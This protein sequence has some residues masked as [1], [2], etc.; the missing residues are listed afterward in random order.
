MVTSAVN[1]AEKFAE[2]QQLNMK[3]VTAFLRQDVNLDLFELCVK[4]MINGIQRKS[5]TSA[6]G[7]IPL[8][9]GRVLPLSS[10]HWSIEKAIMYWLN[11]ARGKN[12]KLEDTHQLLLL[13]VLGNLPEYRDVANGL[14]L[15]MISADR[16]GSEVLASRISERLRATGKQFD[17]GSTTLDTLSQDFKKAQALQ[18]SKQILIQAEQDQINQTLVGF[19]LKDADKLPN[20]QEE[21]I[22]AFYAL[23][24]RCV[25]KTHKTSMDG[26]QKLLVL[27]GGGNKQLIDPLKNKTIELYPNNIETIIGFFD[28]ATTLA[29]VDNFK[30]IANE[31]YNS[32]SIKGANTL[33]PIMKMFG[34]NRLASKLKTSLGVLAL[35]E[36]KTAEPSFAN[37]ILQ[38]W[39]A[40][41]PQGVQ[42]TP[43]VAADWFNAHSVATKTAFIKEFGIGDG[44]KPLDNQLRMI[45]EQNMPH[46]ASSLPSNE[47]SLDKRLDQQSNSIKV[48]Q[49]TTQLLLAAKAFAR[50]VNKQ[51]IEEQ[52]LNKLLS[53]QGKIQAKLEDAKQSPQLIAEVLAAMGLNVSDLKRGPIADLYQF[54]V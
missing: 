29:N 33:P 24:A 16:S 21:G 45:L 37:K 48:G 41:I 30:V 32:Y 47:L 44:L 6:S 38:L 3:A 4:A 40:D 31:A 1:K 17:F 2:A 10:R 8:T 39:L 7:S 42:N 20:T 53:L 9:G 12:K 14:S 13:Q 36:Q 35:I 52:R 28:A 25:A 5:T 46:Y 51:P 49:A 34:E 54:Q 11:S 15:K 18:G 19:L 50:S 23:F 22:D 27:L 26:A 43:S